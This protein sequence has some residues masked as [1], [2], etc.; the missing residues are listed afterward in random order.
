MELRPIP[1]VE[2]PRYRIDSAGRVHARRESRRGSRKRIEVKWEPCQPMKLDKA[3]E[4]ARGRARDGGE[5]LIPDREVTI[6]TSDQLSLSRLTHAAV[7]RVTHVEKHA[8]DDGYLAAEAI[9]ADGDTN[10]GWFRLT[11]ADGVVHVFHGPSVATC[12]FGSKGP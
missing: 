12:I 11:C 6:K 5:L 4:F 2:D 9:P 3:R 8:A 1:F 7:R 10:H